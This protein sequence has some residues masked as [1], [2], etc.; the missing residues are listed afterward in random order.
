V[1]GGVDVD[2]DNLNMLFRF[3]MD[4]D[5]LSTG[6][7]VVR[8]DAEVG[9]VGIGLNLVKLLLLPP[10]PVVVGVIGVGGGVVVPIVLVIV[11]GVVVP[12]VLVIVG[13]VVVVPIAVLS[14]VGGV[15]VAVVGMMR[16]ANVVGFGFGGKG[17]GTSNLA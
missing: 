6:A 9:V 16:G 13:G 11:G 1:V 17:G 12:T 15:V 10:P 7:N 8:V 4:D 3:D 5:V 2:D 14:I